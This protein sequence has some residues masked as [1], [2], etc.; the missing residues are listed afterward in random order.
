[1]WITVECSA[2]TLRVS[3]CPACHL[4]RAGSIRCSREFRFLEQLAASLYSTR[5]SVTKLSFSIQFT[6]FE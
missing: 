4:C 1:M 5:F 6:R 3:S 2:C